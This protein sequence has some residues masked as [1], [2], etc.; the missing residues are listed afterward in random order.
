M[1]TTTFSGPV[2]S[3]NGFTGDVTGN[4]TGAVTATTFDAPSATGLAALLGDIDN[5]YN[6]TGK[7]VGKQVT[8]LDD[9]LIY[10]ATGTDANSAWKASDGTTSITPA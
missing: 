1:A 5:A 10:T 7:V 4:I 9:G 8:D 3:N 2:V 6:T